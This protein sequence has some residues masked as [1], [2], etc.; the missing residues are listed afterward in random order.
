M[1]L[2]EDREFLAQLRTLE[3]SLKP[4]RPSPR[5]GLHALNFRGRSLEFAEYR[6]YREGEDLRDLDWKVWGR[7]DRFYVKLRDAHAPA[8]AMLFLDDSP[9]MVTA[10]PQASVPK[11]QAAALVAF[12]LASV[13]QRN[14]DASSLH[15]LSQP[16]PEPPRSSRRSFLHQVQRLRTV[17]AGQQLAEPRPLPRMRSK[18]ID[19]AFVISDFLEPLDAWKTRLETIQHLAWQTICLQVLDP[20]EANPPQAETELEDA[21]AAERRRRITPEEW[22]QY[23][24]RLEQHQHQLEG[25]CRKKGM[26]LHT[27]ETTGAMASQIRKLLERALWKGSRG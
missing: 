9:S 25:L 1:S 13:L 19:H 11:H 16:Y 26:R 21:E 20:W 14:G 12:G 27:L 3:L 8:T 5:L 4:S 15:L 24:A 23:R 2:L 22:R 7:S 10:S 18:S 6:E 17:A